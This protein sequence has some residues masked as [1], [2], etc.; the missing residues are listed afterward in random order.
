[1]RCTRAQPQVR[2]RRRERVGALRGAARDIL[3]PRPARAGEKLQARAPVEPDRERPGVQRAISWAV[4]VQR[5]RKSCGALPVAK[6]CSSEWLRCSHSC[7][8]SLVLADGTFAFAVQCALF[9]S[10]F[11]FRG[12]QKRTATSARCTCRAAA[13]RRTRPRHSGTSTWR[14]APVV[15]RFF[16]SQ[17]ADAAAAPLLFLF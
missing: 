3:P 11:S 8:R 1:M 6:R 14:C 13:C 4:G 15:A 7:A 17:P 16:F 10:S 2:P 9:L 5:Q 12:A